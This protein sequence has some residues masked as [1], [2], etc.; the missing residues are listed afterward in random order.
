MSAFF[1]RL[2]RD[3]R[4]GAK[5]LL[6]HKLRS[7][8]A[9]LGIVFGVGSVI[10]MLAIGEG[11]SEEAIARIRKLGSRNIIVMARKPVLEQSA[12]NSRAFLSVYG[13][14]YDDAERIAETIPGVSRVV[15]AKTIEKT[16]KLGTR[17]LELR[18]VGTTE[19]WFDLVRRPLVAGRFLSKSDLE[20]SSNVAILTE[21]GAR[22]L[23]AGEHAIGETLTLGGSAW[24]V[25]GIVKSEEGGSAAM[26]TPDAQTDVYVPLSAARE[27]WGDIFVKST[28]GS[29]LREQVQLHCII[30]EAVSEDV[31]EPVAKA[32]ERLLETAH[33]NADWSL[34]V[35]LALLRQARA[36]RRTFSIVLGAIAGISLLVGG[37]GIMNIMLATV[38]ERTREIGIRR[39]I[40]AR[41]S[42][43][44]MQ[45]LVES[46]VLSALGGGLGVAF[47]LLVPWLVTR[48]AAMPTVVTVW[49]LVLS[50][51][52]SVGVGMVFG[53]YP[54]LRASR[55]DPITALRHD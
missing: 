40:G 49:S 39:A 51:G 10:A 4:L 44:V 17:E 25:I 24:R 9:M 30:A 34:S 41:R 28:Q 13:L 1:S 38:T 12:A 20:T 3:V 54:A 2:S 46:L 22:R 21:W 36:T 18:I 7:L 5:S 53:I 6:L 37:I 48:L 8:L 47:G 14:E 43:I 27:R 50:L 32:M 29:R 35:P 45:F 26:Q 42:R 15:P 19:D 16:G 11:A 55:L 31:V 33:K 52:I 23:L